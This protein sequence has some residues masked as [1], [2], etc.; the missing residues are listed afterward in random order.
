VATLLAA[1]CGACHGPEGAE[2]GFRIDDRD[3]AI[4]GGDSGAT[5]IVPG[6]P[7][8]SELFVRIS[9]ADKES[10]MP[11]DGEPL[12]ADEQG[13]LKEWIAAGAVWPDDMQT[14]PESLLPKGDAAPAKGANHWAF[15]PLASVEPPAGLARHPVD[16]F[17]IQAQQA[18]GLS[19][20][21]P[22][23]KRTLIRRATFDLTGLPPTPEEVRAFLDDSSPAAFN[24]VLERLLASLRQNATAPLAIERML[25]G[26]FHGR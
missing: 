15:Q 24:R 8:E 6:K 17:L 3:K 25:I 22:A 2:S 10:R 13:L 12:S 16:A 26:W 14:L 19:P 7:E 9:T 11:A 5:G 23:D 4:A 20:A 18:K 1:Q 21:P